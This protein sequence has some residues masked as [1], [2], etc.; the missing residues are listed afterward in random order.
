M[1]RVLLTF[2]GFHDPYARGL[3]GEEDQP[4]PILTVARELSFERIVLI[5]TPATT[6]NTAET[7]NA[8]RHESVRTGGTA[9]AR[10][11]ALSADLLL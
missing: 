8:L 7:E 4:G 9:I 11:C 5:S 1:A 2:T 6:R 3:V 10:G